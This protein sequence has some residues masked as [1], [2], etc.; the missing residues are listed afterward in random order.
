MAS[1][2]HG[3][4]RW[5]ADLALAT[6][7]FI[8]GTTFVAVKGALLDISTTYFLA[9]RFMVAALC[10]L[11]IL[12]PVIRSE[13]RRL[14]PGL[15]RGAAAGLFL[16][17]GYVLQTAGLRY[18]TAGNSGFLTGLYIVL[19]PLVG[20]ALYRRWPQVRELLGIIVAGAGIVIL[21]MPGTDSNRRFNYGDL[22]TVGCAVAFAFHIVMVGYFSARERYEALAVGQVA[23][24]A[25]LSAASVPFEAPKVTWSSPV[26]LALVL[27]GVFGTAIAFAAQT[28]AQKY[29]TATRA[30]L[31]FALEPV[32]AVVT[33]ILAGHEQL[34]VPVILGGT[35]ILSGILVVELRPLR[36]PDTPNSS[37]LQDYGP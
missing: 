13:P 36:A 32:F 4:G 19:V 16:W 29:T 6:I 37:E 21:T 11:P 5:Q 2:S 10:M 7:A 20:A 14:W 22:L 1:P 26:I 18:T 17:A 23:C 31:L 8:W 35:L 25:V 30:A 27:T 33:A 24:A 3:P 9:L 12:V 28:W 34:T 15:T